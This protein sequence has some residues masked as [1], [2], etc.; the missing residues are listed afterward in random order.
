FLILLSIFLPLEYP[1]HTSAVLLEERTEVTVQ[2]LDLV[3]TK[4]YRRVLVLN[5]QGENLY[6]EFS[7]HYNGY[8]KIKRLE[9]KVL[10]VSGRLLLGSKHSS[11]VDVAL[12]VSNSGITDSRVKSISFS[13]HQLTPPYIIEFISEEETNQ[14]FFYEDWAP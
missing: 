5:R 1:K 7:R 8:T 6:G 11:V 14:S 3:Q 9:A 13:K 4:K 10:D 12:D 2:K